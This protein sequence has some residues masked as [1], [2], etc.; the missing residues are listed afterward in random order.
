MFFNNKTHSS[1]Y[2]KEFRNVFLLLPMTM[3]ERMKAFILVK[4]NFYLKAVNFLFGSAN[5][6]FNQRYQQAANCEEL[7][8]TLS[9]P[10]HEFVS[11]V[12]EELAESFPEK[13]K[14]RQSICRYRMNVFGQ[15]LT[16]SQV[17]EKKE[18]DQ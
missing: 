2:Y 14:R 6:L 7:C 1:D 4:P 10:I 5:R 8:D 3:L 18:Y 17:T 13:Y 16:E 12:P 9:I 11:F 15:N